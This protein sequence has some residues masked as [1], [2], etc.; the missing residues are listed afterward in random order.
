MRFHHILLLTLAAIF[1]SSDFTKAHSVQ[2][3]ENLVSAKLLQAVVGSA[4]S[5]TTKRLLRSR[6][7]ADTNNELRAFTWATNIG[8]NWKKRAEKKKLE[9]AKELYL[10][11]ASYQKFLKE[12]ITP[13]QLYQ[14]MNLQKDMRLALRYY[15][16][17]NRLLT[18]SNYKIWR[19]YERMWMA[20]QKK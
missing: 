20:S 4:P 2:D 8:N 3:E 6:D 11:G 12:K 15:G 13:T 1:V 16:N 5:E 17:W 14:A 10:S 7:T 9:R 19:T 18:N